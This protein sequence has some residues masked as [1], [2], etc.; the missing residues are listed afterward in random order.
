MN[1]TSQEDLNFLEALIKMDD[2]FW[3]FSNLEKP[4][5][6]LSNL[7]MKELF[8]LN[9]KYSKLFSSEKIKETIKLLLDHRISCIENSIAASTLLSE[10]IE[11]NGGSLYHYRPP[12]MVHNFQLS[13]VDGYNG[14][15]SEYR[16]YSRRQ[17]NLEKIIMTSTYKIA[18][19]KPNYNG[20]VKSNLNI[21]KN[22]IES[23]EA[24]SY[25][26]NNEIFL[27][28]NAAIRSL[29]DKFDKITRQVQ[30]K[31]NYIVFDYLG[32]KFS[33]D[34]QK[35]DILSEDEFTLQW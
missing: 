4:I 34:F 20:W 33:I 16:F 19:L 10:K 5:Q 23:M 28:S 12:D 2:L 1:T 27:K 31:N 13:M 29:V 32:T 15:I 14:T 7:S 18:D 24:E 26:L 22:C 6:D 21:P 30:M 25:L 11:E 3:I 17:K 8:D 9:K 35:Q